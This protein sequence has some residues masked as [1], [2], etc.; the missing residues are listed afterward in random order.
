MFLEEPVKAHE[1]LFLF[2]D[3]FYCL[4]NPYA[5][6]NVVLSTRKIKMHVSE[7]KFFVSIFQKIEVIIT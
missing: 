6:G 1:L 7:F 2:H 5:V 3:H 4:D